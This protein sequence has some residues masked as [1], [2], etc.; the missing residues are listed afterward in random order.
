MLDGEPDILGF[1]AR[2]SVP[3]TACCQASQQR[4]RTRG[5]RRQ[6]PG[7]SAKAEASR[8]FHG[9]FRVL[10]ALRLD[11][12][13]WC[14]GPSR[15]RLRSSPPLRPLNVRISKPSVDKMVCMKWRSLLPTSLDLAG[16]L[17]R[18]SLLTATS[19]TG[20]GCSASCR[21]SPRSGT[22]QSHR[23]RTAGRSRSTATR[24]VSSSRCGC[25]RSGAPDEARAPCAYQAWLV[26]VRGKC[27]PRQL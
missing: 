20:T 24:R 16:C 25:G 10:P 8:R 7:R 9:G 6:N 21:S 12:L 15:G 27:A 5:E 3:T 14:R 23:L 2:S 22:M 26:G 1:R 17:P 13:D 18:L 11:A 4:L 19:L